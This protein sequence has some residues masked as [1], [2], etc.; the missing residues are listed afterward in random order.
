[1]LK[2]WKPLILLALA[3]S[4]LATGACLFPDS[5]W[6][7]WFGTF[8]DG[9]TGSPNQMELPEDTVL[10][11]G[12][13]EIDV[14]GGVLALAP[15]SWGKVEEILVSEGQR[16]KGG[17]TLLRLH[18]AL[19]QAQLEQAEATAGQAQL[20]LELARQR[21][22][23][24]QYDREQQTQAMAIAQKRIDIQRLTLVKL[25]KMQR[26]NLIGAEDYQAAKEEL[27]ALQAALVVQQLKGKQLELEDPGRMIALAQ[28][29]L[30]AAQAGR[31]VAEQQLANHQ[32][33]APEDG[34]VLRILV[35]R[36]QF[37]GG[38]QREPAVW[39]LPDRPLLVRCEI[40]QEF[41]QRVAVGQPCE[42]YNDRLDGVRWA[43]TVQRLSG[44][45]APRRL[46]TEDPLLRRDVRTL[47]CLVAL[48]DPPPSLRIGQRVRVAI[49]TRQLAGKP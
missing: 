10:V 38:P 1:M 31:T 34:T 27:A 3:A 6:R 41:A 2:Y 23:K 43:G 32:L 8:P 39:F 17:E 37:L 44:W 5:P 33:T 4:L 35:G 30:A 19:A 12:S 20:R 11:V 15:P 26:D 36:G 29:D 46:T 48:K 21:V 45:M 18:R 22:P 40:E 14:D 7:N 49:R 25:E 9:Q 24:H 16:V 28:K 47:E 42:I 13:G